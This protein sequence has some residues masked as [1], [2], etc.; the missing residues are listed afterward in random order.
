MAGH[1]I[2]QAGHCL[3]PLRKVLARHCV[4]TF[5][6]ERQALAGRWPARD[7]TRKYVSTRGNV[8]VI[9]I[10]FSNVSS[11]PQGCDSFQVNLNRVISRD[12]ICCLNCCCHVG[13]SAEG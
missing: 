13:F 3:I 7:T 9:A 12:G 8:L 5:L 10:C 11:H 1:D 4:L 2:A 6:G